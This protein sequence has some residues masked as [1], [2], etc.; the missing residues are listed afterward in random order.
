MSKQKIYYTRELHL[1]M[2]P[3]VR[4]LGPGLDWQPLH[5]MSDKNIQVVLEALEAAFEAGKRHR[6]HEILKLLGGKA[7]WPG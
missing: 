5:S 7:E 4:L 3:G 1:D 6:G 2:G